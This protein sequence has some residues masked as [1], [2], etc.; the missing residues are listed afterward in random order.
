MR[1]YSDYEIDTILLFGEER[2]LKISHCSAANKNGVAAAKTTVG[3]DFFYS[4]GEKIY[5]SKS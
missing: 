3:K 2:K 1:F 5:L 4:Q